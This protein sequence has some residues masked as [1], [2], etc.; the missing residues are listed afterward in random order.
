LRTQGLCE[1][2]EGAAVAQVCARHGIPF[3]EVRGISN[4]VEDRDLS[5]WN[6]RAGAEIAQ[7]AL[8][9]LLAEPP[10]PEVSA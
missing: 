7:E 2:M 8:F 1:N 3:G 9:A 6:L 4:L 5:R 10:A